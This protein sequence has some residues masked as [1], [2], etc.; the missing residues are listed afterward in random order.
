MTLRS[1]SLPHDADSSERQ[2]VVGF[3]P[4]RNP[5]WVKL[6]FSPASIFSPDPS[7]LIFSILSLSFQLIRLSAEKKKKEKSPLLLQEHESCSVLPTAPANLGILRMPC[8]IYCMPT[9]TYPHRPAT[10]CL[11]LWGF[12]FPIDRLCFCLRCTNIS[13]KAFCTYCCPFP[14]STFLS[15]KS[16]EVYGKLGT[17]ILYPTT[18]A[19]RE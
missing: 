9:L 11:L 4:K 10:C 1:A 15:A 2:H 8:N 13:E 18:F 6:T 19:L 7:L 14:G 12:A 16:K 5:I 3:F 17:E